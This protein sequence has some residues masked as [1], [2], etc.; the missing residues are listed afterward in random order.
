MIPTMEANVIFKGESFCKERC[1]SCAGVKLGSLD[2]A[3]SQVCNKVK[4]ELKSLVYKVEAITI[5]AKKF[6]KNL[7]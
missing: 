1:A 7:L 4:F 5:Q 6:H 2:S 3:T